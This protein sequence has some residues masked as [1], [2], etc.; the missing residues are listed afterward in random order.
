M[1]FSKKTPAQV[2]REI[3]NESETDEESDNELHIPEVNNNITTSMTQPD[4]LD[5]S[6]EDPEAIE[7][8]SF[9]SKEVVQDSK[10]NQGKCKSK[11][12]KRTTEMV[13]NLVKCLSNIKSQ[14]ELKGLDFES[15]YVALYTEA[16]EAMTSLYDEENFGLQKLAEMGDETDPSKCKALI[17]DERKNMKIGYERVNQKARDIRQK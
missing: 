3:A 2:I 13:D 16:R 11:R 8:H 6:P 5:N 1:Y 7:K 4:Q 12:W 9:K 14:Y 17:T 15:D 10:R